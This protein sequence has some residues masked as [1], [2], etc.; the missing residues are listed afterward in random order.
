[1]KLLS[2]VA[3][4]R[5]EQARLV[6]QAEVVQAARTEAVMSS[7]TTCGSDSGGMCTPWCA[8]R[9][10]AQRRAVSW[11]ARAV[12]CGASRGSGAVMVGAPWADQG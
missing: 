9:R 11:G 12:S 4:G 2:F 10:K 8:A 1:M 3:D 6:S 5:A 7:S